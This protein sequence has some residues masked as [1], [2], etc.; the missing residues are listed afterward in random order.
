LVDGTGWGLPLDLF[1]IQVAARNTILGGDGGDL[2]YYSALWGILSSVPEGHQGLTN[3]TCNT[4]DMYAQGSSRFGVCGVPHGDNILVTYAQANNPLGLAAGDQ[5][6]AAGDDSGPALF[7]TAIRRPVCGIHA[8]SDSGQRT[9]AAKTFFGS[10]PTGMTLSVQ[11]GDG[12]AARSVVVPAQGVTRISCQ[13]PLGRDVKFNAK[14][15]VRPDGVAV[16]QLPTFYPVDATLPDNP[17]N[18]Q[19]NTFITNFQASIQAEFDK[20]KTAPAIVWDARGNGGGLTVVGLTIVDGMPGARAF[21][22]SYCVAR[23]PGTQ[24]PSFDP[25]HYAIYSVT[26]GGPF[27]YAG[28]VAVL[29]DGADY[30]AADYFSMAVARATSIPLVGAATSGAYGGLGATFAINGTPA[31]RAFLDVNHCL[32]AAT[33]DALDTHPTMPTMAVDYRP[34]DLRAGVDTVLEAAVALVR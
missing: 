19:L 30:S 25:N 1:A 21:D 26:P 28:K 3:G 9:F 34:E 2:A 12:S 4:A 20:V 31:V 14:A 11:P 6:T 18:D 16:I 7:A 24:P 27:A 29:I 13:D 15:S 10:V 8:P 33:G 23:T 32:D 17:T 22:L 5:I